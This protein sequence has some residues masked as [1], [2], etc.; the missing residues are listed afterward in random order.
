MVI[1]DKPLKMSEMEA[2]ERFYPNSYVMIHCEFDGG[3]VRQ[4]DVVA[5]APPGGRGPLIEY[6]WDLAETGNYGEVRT[7]YTRDPFNGE[8]LMIELHASKA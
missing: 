7:N 1:L 2:N 5:Y 6:G 3:V 8:A 4:G